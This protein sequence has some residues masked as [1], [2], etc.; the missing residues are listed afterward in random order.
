MIKAPTQPPVFSIKAGKSSLVC[1][2]LPQSRAL[3]VGA[4][5]IPQPWTCECLEHLPRHTQN[6]RVRYCIVQYPPW[7]A[8]T[9][10]QFL[11]VSD[12]FDCRLSS[13]LRS[14][15]LDN[16]LPPSSSRANTGARER[17]HY[18]PLPQTVDRNTARCGTLSHYYPL[19]M[20]E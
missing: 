9:A 6:I 20:F 15:R 4:L 10:P 18:E 7:R 16:V 11:M 12:Q 3:R 2:V 19:P 13:A 5:P 8:D 14:T 1:R 17:P